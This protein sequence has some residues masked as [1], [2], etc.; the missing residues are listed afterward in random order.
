MK[1]SWK[2]LISIL[3]I[4]NVALA[5][6]LIWRISATGA[7]NGGTLPKPTLSEGVRGEMGIDANINESNIDKYLGRTDAVSRDMRML[8]DEANYGAIGGD[9]YLSGFVKGFE[10]VPYP[11]LVNVRLILS[12]YI[13]FLQLNKIKN[14]H[15]L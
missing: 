11:K 13:Y 10:V 7:Q 1:K 14:N 9:S 4:V 5:G 12:I 8:V 15:N 6:V 2:V 3:V